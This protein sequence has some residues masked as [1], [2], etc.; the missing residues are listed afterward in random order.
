MSVTQAVTKRKKS[1][2]LAISAI[3]LIRGYQK[4]VSP[5][6]HRLLGV[7]S[8]CRNVPTCSEYAQNAFAQYGFA[9]GVLLS[10]RRLI[11]C[12]PFFKI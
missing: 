7:Q 4:F 3:V 10:I 5:L 8:A 12:Q 2:A 1:R 6:L 9:K 11:N